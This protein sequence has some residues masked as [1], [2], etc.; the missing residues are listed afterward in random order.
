MDN[1][2]PSGHDIGD[3]LD[4]MDI[5][6]MLGSIGLPVAAQAIGLAEN[7]ATGQN[8][9][10]FAYWLLAMDRRPKR[11]HSPNIVL[12]KTIVEDTAGVTKLKSDVASARAKG[13]TF[14]DIAFYGHGDQNLNLGNTHGAEIAWGSPNRSGMGNV[15]RDP[16][17]EDLFKGAVTPNV[18]VELN[19]CHSLDHSMLVTV[20]MFWR[21]LAP[22]A[23]IWGVYGEV[24]WF[25]DYTALPQLQ[26]YDK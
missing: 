24:Y 13:Y 18:R 3:M 14:T 11:G 12:G 2:D 23:D 7:V 10:G 8:G 5:G 25:G 9:N 16:E 19:F 26:H 4:I 20:P 17:L 22:Q 21:E 1:G 6:G 15:L